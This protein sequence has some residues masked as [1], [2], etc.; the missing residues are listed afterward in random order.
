MDHSCVADYA[1][2]LFSQRLS[3]LNLGVFHSVVPDQCPIM[4][5]TLMPKVFN[6]IS[7]FF[8][9]EISVFVAH[10]LQVSAN[11]FDRI[12]AVSTD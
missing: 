9:H 10:I 3:N 5:V 8:N 12:Q 1:A 6:H 4:I 11:C 7:V 2:V